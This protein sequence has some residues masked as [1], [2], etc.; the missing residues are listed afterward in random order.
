[1]VFSSLLFIYLFFAVTMFVYCYVGTIQKKN[2]VLLIASLIF[3]AWGGPKYLIL[4]LVMALISWFFAIQIH[5]FA[6]VRIKAACAL[7]LASA[8]SWLCSDILN[9]RDYSGKCEKNNRSS[10]SDTG[11]CT[12]YRNFF[13]HVPADLLCGGCLSGRSGACKKK[14]WLV[15]LYCSLFHQCIAGRSFVIRMWPGRLNT[16]GLKFRKSDG[17]STV[18]PSGLSKSGICKFLCTDCGYIAS[19]GDHTF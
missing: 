17:G 11:N 13:L 4:L 12:S 10:G 7:C 14:Y 8:F 18:L 15:L 9:M 19:G 5:H 3:Y 16:A 6:K 2:V 1:M